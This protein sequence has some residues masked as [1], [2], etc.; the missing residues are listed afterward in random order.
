MSQSDDEDD[1]PLAELWLLS[2]YAA[3]TDLLFCDLFC[4]IISSYE[5]HTVSVRSLVA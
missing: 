4:A 2:K 3:A 5:G 1:N